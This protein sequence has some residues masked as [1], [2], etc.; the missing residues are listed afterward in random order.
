[1]INNIAPLFMIK[2]LLSSAA[3]LITIFAF[4]PYIR[5][6]LTSTIRPHVFTW[7]IWGLSTFIVGLAQFTARAGVGVWP[8]LISGLITF[9]IAWLAYRKTSDTTIT[10]VDWLCFIAALS[11][12]PCWY[13]THDPLSA[14]IILTIIDLLGYGPTLRKAYIHPHE[15]QA[16]LYGIMT[17]RNMLVIGSFEEYSLTTLLF[18]IATIIANMIVMSVLWTRR[19][20]QNLE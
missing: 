12:I 19:T 15:E 1:M 16:L 2:A 4:V 8:I 14:V 20:G 7:I 6:I 5:G 3:T 18:P 9:Y 11:A 13:L 10:P 17:F